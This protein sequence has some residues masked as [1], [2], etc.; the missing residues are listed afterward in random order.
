MIINNYVIFI[1]LIAISILYLLIHYKNREGLAFGL[2]Y[3]EDSYQRLGV[4]RDQE[5]KIMYLGDKTF[6]YS[7]GIN[8]RYA[9]DI[10]NSKVKSTA[11]LR[12]NSV[13]VADS[14]VW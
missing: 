14:V 10:A 12:K 9:A 6:D 8:N 5:N 3:M 7:A 13:P 1:V 11:L 4:V 2:P